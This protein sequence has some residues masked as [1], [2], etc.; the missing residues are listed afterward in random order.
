[1]AMSL[2][3]FPRL[4]SMKIQLAKLRETMTAEYKSIKSYYL[5]NR[6]G[7]LQ[8][9]QLPAYIGPELHTDLIGCKNL[10]EKGFRIIQDKDPRI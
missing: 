6:A 4:Q 2:R 7:E 3:E 9:V 5:R 1:M 10:T 8:P